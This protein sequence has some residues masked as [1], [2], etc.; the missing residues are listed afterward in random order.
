MCCSRRSEPVTVLWW[1]RRWWLAGEV[2][3]EAIDGIEPASDWLV[4]RFA[5]EA[6]PVRVRLVYQPETLES[7]LVGCPH[8]ARRELAQALAPEFPALA[9]GDRAWGFEPVLTKAEAAS[10]ILHFEREPGLIALA[11]RL[12]EHGI[13]VDSAWPLTTF[14]QAVPSEWSQ[15]GA[16]AVLA[17][18]RDEAVA[19]RHARDG[20]RE[21]QRWSD[22]ALKQASSWLAATIGEDL[23]DSVVVVT[24]DAAT[25]AALAE[26]IGVQIPGLEVYTIAQVLRRHVVLPRYH[27]AQL[28]PREPTALGAMLLKAASVALFLTAAGLSGLLGLRW[29]AARATEANSTAQLANLQTDLRQLRANAAELATLE[30]TSAVSPPVS[31]FLDRLAR[32]IPPD[33]VLTS[34]R[35]DAGG[36]TCAGW[37]L[38]SATRA[39]TAWQEALRGPWSLNMSATA[40]G[41]FSL[42][43]TFR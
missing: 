21:V 41:A 32:T 37:V 15:S 5:E 12:A 8:G 42:K 39:L 13:A 28:L 20:G 18:D 29:H 9:S 43:G 33:V 4:R 30:A 31:A 40:D 23:A 22:S 24:D 34:V 7:V 38:P 17:I 35:V 10:T 26:V 27:P 3:S 1:R 6:K 11:R 25:Q 2:V 14:L 19:F 16:L 36:V